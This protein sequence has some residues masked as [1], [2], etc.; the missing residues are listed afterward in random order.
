MKLK[1]LFLLSFVILSC[2]KKSNELEAQD[3]SVN[4]FP[5]KWSLYKMTGSIQYSE[6]TGDDL[7]YQEYYIFYRDKSFTKIRISDSNERSA[8]GFFEIQSNADGVAYLLNYSEES[9]LVDNCSNDKKEYLY[10][11]DQAIT[12][13]SSWQAC[14]GPGLF[15][16]Q[17]SIK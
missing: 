11:D 10:L 16:E 4:T 5:Q 7:P 8:V 3:L 12:L 13:I 9:D 14:D 17:I 6:R 2:S 1:F 15:Y